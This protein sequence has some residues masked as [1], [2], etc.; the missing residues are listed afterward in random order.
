MMFAKINLIFENNVCKLSIF[1]DFRQHKD[2][3]FV[4]KYAL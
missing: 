3:D 2:Y 4:Q 1:E